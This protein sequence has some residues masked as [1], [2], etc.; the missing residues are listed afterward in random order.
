MEQ[1]QGD[2]ALGPFQEALLADKPHAKWAGVGVGL[3]IYLAS[4]DPGPQSQDFVGCDNLKPAVQT[5]GQKPLV[6]HS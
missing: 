2:V 5:L 1:G 6:M 4:L 3:H